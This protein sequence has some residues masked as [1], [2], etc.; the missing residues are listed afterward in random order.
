MTTMD[1][2]FSKAMARNIELIER[3]HERILR[4][5]LREQDEEAHTKPHDT[6]ETSP[7]PP[8]GVPLRL[9]HSQD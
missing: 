4:R 9:V 6:D 7:Q 8:R 1:P 3:M 2:E 5:V